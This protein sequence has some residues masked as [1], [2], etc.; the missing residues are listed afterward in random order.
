MMG[1][2]ARRSGCAHRPARR[3]VAAPDWVRGMDR[4]D[5]N[6]WTEKKQGWL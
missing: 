3:P 5:L 4:V 2:D 6:I 1:H